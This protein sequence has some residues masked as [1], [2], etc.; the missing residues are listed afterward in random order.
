MKVVPHM[1][2]FVNFTRRSLGP[3]SGT[4]T[5]SIQR[6]GSALRFTRAFIKIYLLSIIKIIMK[7]FDNKGKIPLLLIIERNL[8]LCFVMRDAQ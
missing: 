6:P 1:A 4:G 3:I 8:F 7:N 2:V 5:S